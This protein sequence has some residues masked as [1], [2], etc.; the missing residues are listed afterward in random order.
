[1]APRIWR[2]APKDN[3]SCDASEMYGSS[4]DGSLDHNAILVEFWKAEVIR[5]SVT[6]DLRSP[7]CM[8]VV[9]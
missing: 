9:L 3:I 2:F 6:G 1:M 7:C 4:S 8:F 5:I